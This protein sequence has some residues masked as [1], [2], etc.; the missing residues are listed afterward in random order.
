VHTIESAA[1][2]LV[3]RRLLAIGIAGGAVVLVPS[4]WVLFRVFKSERASAF[5]RVNAAERPRS[6]SA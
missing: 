6:F 1:A 2:P 3:T 5:E 4:L